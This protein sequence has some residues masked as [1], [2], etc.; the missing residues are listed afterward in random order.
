MKCKFEEDVKLRRHKFHYGLTLLIWAF[1]WD[2][3]KSVQ[4]LEKIQVHKIEVSQYL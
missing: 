2:H 4:I 3:A 1:G